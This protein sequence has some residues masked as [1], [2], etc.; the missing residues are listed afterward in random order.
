MIVQAI[1][2]FTP[3]ILR[4]FLSESF[5]ST[6]NNQKDNTVIASQECNE[7]KMDENV[8]QED[9]ETSPKKNSYEE[10]SL[11]ES[12]NK[13]NSIYQISVVLIICCERYILYSFYLFIIIENRKNNSFSDN[14]D[15]SQKSRSRSRLASCESN[16]KSVTSS[17]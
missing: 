6:E 3:E 11:K 10:K 12:D 14:D 5:S 7:K 2:N 4:N 13:K 15:N 9:L 8:V 16:A 1:H 17:K